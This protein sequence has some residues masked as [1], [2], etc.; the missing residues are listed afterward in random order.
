MMIIPVKNVKGVQKDD[1]SFRLSWERPE[2]D[3]ACS[4]LW[5]LCQEDPSSPR[6]FN[7]DYRMYS[8][9]EVRFDN[10]AGNEF[11]VLHFL[12][13]LT[14]SR[15]TPD[16]SE[17]AAF[18]PAMVPSGKAS[19]TYRWEADDQ[20]FCL[21]LQNDSVLPAESLYYEY[22]FCGVRFHFNVPSSMTASVGEKKARRL[23]FPQGQRQSCSRLIRI[24]G[25]RGRISE[26]PAMAGAEYGRL[27][28]DINTYERT[29]GNGTLSNQMH[30]L[31]ADD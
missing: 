8:G 7:Y 3:S 10:A 31:H 22:E 23:H 24:S 2:G 27:A 21:V 19:V 13:L 4:H 17:T 16:R 9:A 20:R 29:E 18:Q 15:K 1:G 28:G 30:S 25:L 12:V 14:D 11:T 5:V 26:N 6:L